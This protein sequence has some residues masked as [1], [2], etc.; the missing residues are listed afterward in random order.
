M[1]VGA[2]FVSLPKTIHQSNHAKGVLRQGILQNIHSGSITAGY[3][4]AG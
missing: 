2:Y 4:T 3:I 1:Y